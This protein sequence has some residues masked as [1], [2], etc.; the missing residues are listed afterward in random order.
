MGRWLGGD[1]QQLTQVGAAGDY[2]VPYRYAMLA[3]SGGMLHRKILKS[4]LIFLH[5]GAS[6]ALFEYNI[7]C[8]FQEMHLFPLQGDTRGGGVNRLPPP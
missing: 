3:G 8:I 7:A 1:S 4:T 6:G 5:S 2:R